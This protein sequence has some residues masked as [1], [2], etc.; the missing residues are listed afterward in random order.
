MIHELFKRPPTLHLAA[1]PLLCDTERGTTTNQLRT[2][3]MTKDE[4]STRLDRTLRVFSFTD[5]P[6]AD[7]LTRLPPSHSLQTET[8]LIVKGE[9]FG[10][11][12]LHEGSTCMRQGRWRPARVRFGSRLTRLP[13]CPLSDSA[14]S[15]ASGVHSR[16]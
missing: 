3:R 15:A 9:N 13:G 6:V 11:Y 2:K 7:R 12:Y 16:Q 10:L 4:L 8:V 5:I 14:T 1:C